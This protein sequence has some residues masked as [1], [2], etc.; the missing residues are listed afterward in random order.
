MAHWKKST[1]G[2]RR[3][4]CIGRTAAE[5]PRRRSNMMG[6][7]HKVSSPA[8]KCNSIGASADA[9]PLGDKAEMEEGGTD[10]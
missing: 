5:V 10:H 9:E 7:K 3:L 1:P 8:D 2:C 6:R 4:S